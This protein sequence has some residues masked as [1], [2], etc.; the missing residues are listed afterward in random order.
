MPVAGVERGGAESQER[1]L[2]PGLNDSQAAHR[3]PQGEQ[4]TRRF[5][6]S[7]SGV[8]QDLVFDNCGLGE[9]NVGTFF[10]CVHT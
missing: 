5:V 9:K 1:A 2:C 3:Y 4:K 7:V 8:E 10:L 6:N